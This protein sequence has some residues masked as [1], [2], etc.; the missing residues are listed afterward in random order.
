MNYGDSA[1]RGKEAILVQ[2]LKR[3]W[4]NVRRGVYH[5]RNRY[6]RQLEVADLSQMRGY[7]IRK[8]SREGRELFQIVICNKKNARESFLLHQHR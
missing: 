4:A 6:V 8:C 1:M 2:N 5:F 3:I 7:R